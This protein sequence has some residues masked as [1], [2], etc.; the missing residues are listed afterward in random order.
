MIVVL[1]EDVEVPGRCEV[2]RRAIL[3]TLVFQSVYD[4]QRCNGV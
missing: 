4:E 3:K 1:Q 2:V